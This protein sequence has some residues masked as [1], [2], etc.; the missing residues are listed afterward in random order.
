MG[1]NPDGSPP[2]IDENDLF[3]HTHEDESTLTFEKCYPFQ[4]KNNNYERLDSPDMKFEKEIRD[5]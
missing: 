5:V 3:V 4:R 2:D 1:K